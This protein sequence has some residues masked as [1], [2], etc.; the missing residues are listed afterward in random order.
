[1][2]GFDLLAESKIRQWEQDVREGRIQ[3]SKTAKAE[4]VG[5]Y[6]PLEKKLFRDIRKN[7]IKAYMSSGQE[8][9]QLLEDAGNM[10]VQ[11]SSR[12]E[13]SGYNRMSK[14]FSDTIQAVKAAAGAAE[15]DLETLRA[16]LEEMD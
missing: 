5:Q 11:L 16:M 10:H 14:M 6:E 7:I 3:P 9:R 1:M 15:Q 4:S 2:T 13:R 12:L 8:R